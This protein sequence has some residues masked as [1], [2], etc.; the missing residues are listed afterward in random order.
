MQLSESLLCTAIVRQAWE[1][2]IFAD[3]DGRIRLWNLGA[4]T[5]FGHSADEAIG[6]SLDIIVPERF[7]SAHWSG[8]HKAIESGHTRHGGEVR[9]TRALHKDGRKLYVELSFGLITTPAGEVAGS[10]AIGRPGNERYA[11]DAGMQARIAALES[12]LAG[13]RPA[14]RS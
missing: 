6:A 4:E 3:R 2:V 5:M 12:E 11:K 1:A 13:L 8:F 9:T 14:P 7:R 10:L